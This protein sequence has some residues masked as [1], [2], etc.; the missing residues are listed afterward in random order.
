M[1]RA[2]PGKSSKMPQ[3]VHE[4][5]TLEKET[6]MPSHVRSSSLSRPPSTYIAEP[7]SFVRAVNS[8]NSANPVTQP[9]HLSESGRSSAKPFLLHRSH[10]TAARLPHAARPTVPDSSEIQSSRAQTSSPSPSISSSRS[11]ATTLADSTASYATPPLG[12]SPVSSR[13]ALARRPPASRSSHGIETSSGPPPALITRRSYTTEVARRRPAP[14]ELVLS[15]PTLRGRSHTDS[16][17]DSKAQRRNFS[18]DDFTRAGS[19]RSPSVKRR[20]SENTTENMDSRTAAQPPPDD[21]DTDRT[22]RGWRGNDPSL[23]SSAR[24]EP[25]ATPQDERSGSLQEDEHSKT[26]QEDEHSKSVLDDEHSKSLQEDEPSKLA[27]EDEHSKSSQED[28]FLDLAKSDTLGEDTTDVLSKSGSRSERRHVSPTLLP[29]YPR[30]LH[31]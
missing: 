31:S 10:S 14:A 3:R 11:V 8:A 18:V 5:V 17:L 6:E 12:V 22:F 20:E 27:Q 7:I 19:W 1:L 15:R 4:G 2:S 26:W 30:G 29:P 16:R 24:G 9:W 13:S 25:A 23:T 21:D 28:L